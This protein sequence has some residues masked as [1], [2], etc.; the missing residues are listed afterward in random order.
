MNKSGVPENP[1]VYISF[2][3][4]LLLLIFMMPRSSKF[5]YDYRKGSTWKYET[6]FAQFDFPIY[7]TKDQIR[8]EM[9][10]S[11]AAA[12]PYYKY[13]DEVVNRNIKSVDGL[14]F[15][16]LSSIKPSLISVLRSIYSH[17][18]V[19]DEGRGGRRSD[20]FDES[21]IYVQKDKRASKVPGSEVYRQSDAMAKLLAEMSLLYPQYNLDSLFK[22]SGVYDLVVPNLI[23][24]EQ[25]TNMVHAD[26]DDNISPTQ[27]YVKAGQ[28]IVSEGELITAE[29][30]QM[31]DSYR[32]E[33]DA[34]IGY[35]GP[36]V[37]YWLGGII[38]SLVIM[39]IL[40]FVILLVDKS[41]FGAWNKLSYILFIFLLSSVGAL[42]VGREEPLSL[43]LVPFVLAILYL[44]KFFRFSTIVPIYVVCLL[45][46]TLL[47]QNG[48]QLF[49]MYFI[50]GL[51]SAYMYR[52]GAKGWKQFIPSFVSFIILVVTYF[53]L[54]M[55]G[56]LDSDE[57][58][59][60][61][62]LFI[63]S[64]I[65]GAADPLA[66]LFERIFKLLSNT[67]LVELSDTENDLIRE[68]ED[69]APGTFQHCLQVMSMSEA[70]AR[71][72][73][74]NILL[75]RAGALYHDIGKMMNPMCFVENSSIANAENP[76]EKADEYHSGLTPE[77]SAH[78]IIRHVT[79]GIE[80]AEKRHLP[81]E[82]IDFIRTHHG[83]TRTGYFYN[84]F[85][86]DGGDP[87]N[88]EPFTYKGVKPQ[89]KEQVIL[90]LCDSIEAGS[91]TLKDNSPKTYSDFVE[92]IAA[93]K[94]A[95]GQFDEAGITIKE[96]NTVKE[97]IKSYLSQM[98]HD[99]V[100]YPKR[101]LSSNRKI[102]K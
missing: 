85:V 55:L 45:P 83:T 92:A 70:A 14:S 67:R 8:E 57:S 84:K 47:R 39:A 3:I 16:N 56:L 4:V 58:T 26:S 59:S 99:R 2:A 86:N 54:E 66:Y 88:V 69:K 41:I 36:K 93:G 5:D 12:I 97:T 42:C 11:Q 100:A 24:D 68:L 25:T 101:R 30:A 37:I 52:H 76:E 78:D 77:Q 27:G 1:K 61:L 53:G 6:L 13:S 32:V 10:G 63:G 43:L 60:I 81:K 22:S 65:T 74:A 34:N 95:E 33:Y 23:F 91:R 90:M 15:G 7:K 35:N 21:L 19:Q 44:R 28:L 51:A 82:I 80:L 20:D 94:A 62:Y 75:I 96:L 102:I 9:S 72:V 64:I 29:I 17:G 73:D 50:A 87:G 49:V 71:A 79:D 38:I 89:T 31:L 40:F 46:L 98:N 18:I 48:P